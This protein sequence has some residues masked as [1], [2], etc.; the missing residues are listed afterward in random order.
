MIGASARSHG[1]QRG[2]LQP[3]ERRQRM[4][5]YVAIYRQAQPD[6]VQQLL[7]TI[8]RS[9]AASRTATPG[10][11]A[12]RVFQRLNEPTTLLSLAEW[13]SQDAFEAYRASPAFDE[14]TEDIGPPPT[15]DYLRRLYLFERM[16]ER[17]AVVASA[18]ITVD[19]AQEANVY[20]YL[21]GSAQ[22]A[23]VG[24]P[25]LVSREVYQRTGTELPRACFLVVHSWRTLA[26]LEHFRNSDVSQF[27][28]SLTRW[29]AV[30]TRFTGEIAAE[31]SRV[32]DA[33][34]G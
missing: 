19:A 30:V 5:F 20:G 11:Q 28:A 3:T 24:R 26:D 2:A 31:Y 25:G 16:N 1:A 33:P 27:E 34:H 7:S 29:G 15:L 10:R 21:M 4:S 6:R 12:A 18:T 22:R 17:A 8:R 13:D 23:M 9:F 32:D 14:T